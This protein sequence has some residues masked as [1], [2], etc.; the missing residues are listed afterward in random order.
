MPERLPGLD[1]GVLGRVARL[2][3]VAQPGIRAA[4]GHVLE[5][6]DDRPKGSAVA[7]ASRDDQ[8]SQMHELPW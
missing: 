1:K 4:K 8:F 7:R 2:L 5:A 6:A 3:D